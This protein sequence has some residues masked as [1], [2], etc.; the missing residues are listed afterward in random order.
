ME[1][2]VC[3]FKSCFSFSRL[4]YTTP[5][6]PSPTMSSVA[7]L[8][9]FKIPQVHNEPMVSTSHSARFLFSSVLLLLFE[10]RLRN[11]FIMSFGMI[12]LELMVSMTVVSAVRRSL[13]WS[14]DVEEVTETQGKRENQ[15]SWSSSGSVL[16]ACGENGCGSKSRQ[17]N[18]KS[19]ANRSKGLLSAV[20]DQDSTVQYAIP[21]NDRKQRES[22]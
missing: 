14:Y 17:G 9:S 4:F 8:A 18:H 15:R 11:E 3:V 22:H 12:S 19:L 20:V 2:L 5:S 21:E 6:S 10:T 1:F 13:R 7:Q 16:C